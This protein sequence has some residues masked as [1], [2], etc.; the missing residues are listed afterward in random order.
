MQ[1]LLLVGGGAALGAMAR[2]LV[3]LWAIGQ[4]GL[5]FPYGT[6]LINASGSLVLAVVV[7]FTSDR[8]ALG[9]ELR[10][11]LG[12]GFCGGYTTFSTFAVETL[13]LIALQRYLAAT[14]YVIASV[15]LSLA[16]AAAGFWLARLA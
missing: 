13:A 5:G 14:L 15:L 4:L 2:Y 7:S 9:P 16:G 1:P 6:L 12:T 3:G 10:L 8:L 11:L